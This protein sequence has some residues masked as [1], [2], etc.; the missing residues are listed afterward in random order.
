M[1]VPARARP[2]ESGAATATAGAGCGAATAG[3]DTTGAGGTATGR[4]GGLEAAVG[5]ATIEDV[6]AAGTGAF[7]ALS[8]ISSSRV[9]RQSETPEI[10]TAAQEVERQ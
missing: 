6:V 3:L 5:A 10:E 7:G 9:R 1:A 4:A 8:L 2:A